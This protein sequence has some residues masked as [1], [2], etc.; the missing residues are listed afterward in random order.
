MIHQ[1]CVATVGAVSN[2]D[3]LNINLGKAG[4]KRWLGKRPQVRGVAMNP[5]DPLM[6]VVKAGLLVVV[7]L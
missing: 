7:T 6:V 1:T 2:T 4:R 3:H 5:V